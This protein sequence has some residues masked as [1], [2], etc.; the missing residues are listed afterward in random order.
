M[1]DLKSPA[2]IKLKAALFLFAGV[3]SSVLLLIECTSLKVVLL[4]A[5]AVWS[6]CRLYYFAFYVIQT[7]LDPEFRFS[8]LLSAVRFLLR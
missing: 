3:F 5:I 7:Y 6:F 2:L 8:G 1:R 4:L